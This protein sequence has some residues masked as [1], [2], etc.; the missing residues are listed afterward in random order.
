MAATRTLTHAGTFDL[1]VADCRITAARP[2]PGDPDPAPYTE[3]LVRPS[4]ARVNRAA[5]RRSWLEEGPGANPHRRGREPLIEVELDRA[6]ELVAGELL[7]VRDTHGPQAIFAGSYGW[8][9]PGRFHHAQ[10]QLKRFLTQFGGFTASEGTYSHGAAEAVV[11][12]VL[13]RSFRQLLREHRPVEEVARHTELLVSFGG[14]PSANRYL[15]NGGTSRHVLR[16]A[17]L[18]ARDRG[19]RFV[20]VSPTRSDLEEELGARWLPLRPGSDTAVLLAILHV[21]IAE[22]LV[23]LTAARRLSSGLDLLLDEVVSSGSGTAPTPVWAA[24]QSGLAAE[25]ITALAHEMADARTLLN[26]TWSIQRTEHGEQALWALLAAATVLGQLHLPGGGFGLGYGSSGSVGAPVCHPPAPTL[27]SGGENPVTDHI[28]VARIADLLL[29]P[30]GAYEVDGQRRRYPHIELVYWAGG[31]PFHHH[32]D[33]HRL[34]RAWSRPATVV[35]HEPFWTATARRAD[36]VLPATTPLE[37]RDL[38]GGTVDATLVA[39]PRVLD[40]PGE[41]CDDHELLRRLAARLGF[42]QRFTEG[43][44]VDGWL[45]WLYERFRAGDP[46]LPEE[47]VFWDRGLVHRSPVMGVRAGWEAFLADPAAAPL[48][49]S[50]GRIVLG[51]PAHA[52]QGLPVTAA[53]RPPTEWLGSA[54]SAQLHLL[55]PQPPQQLHSQHDEVDADAR[56]GARGR[57]PVWM[58]PEDAQAR[59]IADGDDVRIHNRRGRCLATARLTTTV[60]PGVVSLATGAWWDP[61]RDVD[62]ATV[63]RRGNPNVLTRDVPTSTWAQATSA[64]TCL[65]EVEPAPDAPQPAPHAPPTTRTAEVADA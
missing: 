12:R 9:S 28:P 36:V 58:H 54:T 40:P 39:M 15:V 32:Q 65:V 5:V 18:A 46:T 35:V 10:S 33:L 51:D 49:T 50:S 59:G 14:F 2:A 43:R 26:A 62:G 29:E 1:E 52:E 21:L 48:P 61:A 22:E 7:R 11:P 56:R 64:H 42:E 19:C 24:E 47:S 34:E 44:D 23:D 41:A 31:N 57:E 60:M 53:W 63:C 37:R 38:G 3:A 16:E 6:L 45:S 8:A 27:P 4:R 55:S 25:D 17:L 13:G 20:A 30:G